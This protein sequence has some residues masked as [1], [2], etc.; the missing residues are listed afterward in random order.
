M[1]WLYNSSMSFMMCKEHWSLQFAWHD[2]L[3]QTVCM[4]S[5]FQPWGLS[6]NITYSEKHSLTSS[7]YTPP[8]PL[9][10]KLLCTVLFPDL[11]TH[12]LSVSFP[13]NK[14]RE[15]RDL[16]L[17]C[18]AYSSVA[19]NGHLNLWMNEWPN[20]SMIKWQDHPIIKD[21]HLFWPFLPSC[22]ILIMTLNLERR[23]SGRNEVFLNRSSKDKNVDVL[24][25]SSWIP[26]EK[27]CES[28][29]RGVRRGR[30]RGSHHPL[31]IPPLP[32]LACQI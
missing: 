27:L 4:A 19:C 9:P 25:E 13:R 14:L 2:L 28:T 21:S 30:G 29:C 3:L 18:T 11:F 6:W 31:G 20:K 8:P 16:S 26:Q 5:S 22:K 32:S 15:D 1:Y 24:T 12:A 7:R 17:L 23:D 10:S